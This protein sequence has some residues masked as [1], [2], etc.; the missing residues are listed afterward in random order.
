MNPKAPA[1]IVVLAARIWGINLNLLRVIH[2]ALCSQGLVEVWLVVF[3]PS[4]PPAHGSRVYPS[5]QDGMN[6]GW[7][8]VYGVQPDHD[9]A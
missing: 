7:S 5:D 3:G 2:P 9:K 6:Q 4:H 1:M 8:E